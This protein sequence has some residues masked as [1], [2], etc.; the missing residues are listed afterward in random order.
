MGCVCITHV[1]A[2]VDTMQDRCMR[3]MCHLCVCGM[4]VDVCGC[5]LYHV[6]DVCVCV[7]MRYMCDLCV[8]CVWRVCM[9]IIY[10]SVCSCVC[11]YAYVLYDVHIFLPFLF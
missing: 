4:H 10:G 2:A 1:C 6:C 8:T 11:C 5:K 9:C 3:Y 7:C